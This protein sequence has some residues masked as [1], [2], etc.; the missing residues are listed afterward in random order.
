M[1]AMFSE[2]F[3]RV[4]C[5]NFGA[6]E[7]Q[8]TEE[9]CSMMHKY[10]NKDNPGFTPPSSPSQHAQLSAERWYNA[11]RDLKR[12]HEASKEKHSLLLLQYERANEW[13]GDSDAGC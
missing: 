12:E 13:K 2:D 1:K 7:Q 6:V 10:H 3:T 5:E 9:L 4:F 8:I 11:Y